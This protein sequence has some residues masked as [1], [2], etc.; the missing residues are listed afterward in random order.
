[1]DQGLDRFGIASGFGEIEAWIISPNQ[2]FR[3]LSGI[4]REKEPDKEL[5]RYFSWRLA[6]DMRAETTLLFDRLLR[7]VI[8]KRNT[9]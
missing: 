4:G 7:G 1:M 3:H 9:A 2:P 8:S 5:F 6:E